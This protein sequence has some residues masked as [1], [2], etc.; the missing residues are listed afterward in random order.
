ME[1][2]LFIFGVLLFLSLFGGPNPFMLI[3]V[4]LFFGFGLKDEKL[5]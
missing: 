1:K 3:F 4:A 5:D 2:T